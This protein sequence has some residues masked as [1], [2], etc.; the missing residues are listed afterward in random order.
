MADTGADI[1]VMN[2]DN[3]KYIVLDVKVSKYH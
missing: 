2:Q 1:L 3:S